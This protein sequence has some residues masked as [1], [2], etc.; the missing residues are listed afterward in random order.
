MN[1]RLRIVRRIKPTSPST[2][3]G[4]GGAAFSTLQAARV[5]ETTRVRESSSFR[6][7]EEPAA[8][9]HR[10]WRIRCSV[11]NG[12]GPRASAR[13]VSISEQAKCWT[14]KFRK[15]ELKVCPHNSCKVTRTSPIPEITEAD[16]L[17]PLAE[18]RT[19][20]LTSDSFFEKRV[21]T[22]ATW[23]YAGGHFDL[24]RALP[25]VAVRAPSSPGRD[26]I[27]AGGG[28]NEHDAA[29]EVETSVIVRFACY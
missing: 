19:G 28:R 29:V 16:D 20:P 6:R 21:S 23:G 7:V 4:C 3:G 8:E 11:S 5:W 2:G 9:H 13:L 24:V 25:V 27:R 18:G 17:Q 14:A 10:A 26:V 15:L 1:A 12:D 22:K